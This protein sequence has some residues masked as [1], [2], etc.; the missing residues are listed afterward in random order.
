[1]PDRS[2][3][4]Q[5]REIRTSESTSEGLR[6]R[7]VSAVLG[8]EVSGVALAD[9]DEKT[10]CEIERAFN[11]H[12]VLVFRDQT[13]TPADQIRFTRHFGEVAR[14]PLYRSAALDGHPE[15]LVLD[16]KDSQFING[17]NDMWHSDITFAEQPP[18]GSVLYCKSATTGLGDTLFCSMRQAYE[19]L[20]GGLK[21][22]LSGLRAEHSAGKMAKLNNSRAYNVPITEVPPSV[23]HPVVRSHPGNGRPSL[24]VNPI[25]TVTIEGMTDQESD[26]VLG[27]LY[28]EAIRAENIY[29]HR[30]RIGDVVMF[31]NRCTMHY[32]VPDYGL[33]TH[34]LMHRTTAAGDR[35]RPEPARTHP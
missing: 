14:H 5:T 12:S 33:E 27:P 7:P 6:V 4:V 31:D 35:P 29:R 16:H 9:A 19:N 2:R 25:Y 30:W 34:R 15:V 22:A 3:A 10:L 24:F 1:M 20:S 13:L 32:V 17:R 21:T 26:A 11:E 23:L 28:R 18:L 8:A